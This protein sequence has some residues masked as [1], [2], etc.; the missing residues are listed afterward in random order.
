VAERAGRPAVPSRTLGL[1]RVLDDQRADAGR[2]TGQLLDRGGLAVQVDRDEGP[3]ARGHRGRGGGHVQ[4]VGVVV[5]AVGQHRDGTSAPDRL[6][7]RYERVGGH[8][9]LVAGAN[10]AGPQRELD[11]VGAVGHAH[12]VG[13]PGKGREL[14]LERGYPR[15]ADE[16]R[17][18]EHLLPA[19]GDFA[20]YD[21]VL[22]G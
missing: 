13:D 7:G 15:S 3:G 17:P 22:G 6:G 20:G 10:A 2:Q 5:R 16:R 12:A 8:D 18:G 14:A 1:G 11:R 9:D 19:P 4:Q 21:R